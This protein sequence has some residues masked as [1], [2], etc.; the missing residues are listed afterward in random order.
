[1]NSDNKKKDNE[2]DL[3]DKNV[4]ADTSVSNI[5]SEAFDNVTDI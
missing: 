3:F 4:L 2:K 1:M 5:I